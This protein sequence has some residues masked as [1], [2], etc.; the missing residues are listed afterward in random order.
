MSELV[1]LLIARSMLNALNKRPV[2]SNPPPIEQRA[3]QS[4]A[5]AERLRQLAE[6]LTSVIAQKTA[7]LAQ[8]WTPK[9]GREHASRSHDGR[10]LMRC[11]IAMLKLADGIENDSLPATLR[12][13]KWTKKKILGMVST[14]CDTSAGY[15]DYRELFDE[16][17]DNSKRAVSLRLYAGVARAVEQT[18]D[19][20]ALNEIRRNPP[21][22]FFPTPLAVVELMLEKISDWLWDLKESGH[23]AWM[24]E[25]SAGIG[26]LIDAFNE[27]CNE[28]GIPRRFDYCETNIKL[29]DY[30]RDNCDV[31]DNLGFDFMCTNVARNVYNVILMNPP[32]EK[33]QDIDHVRKAYDVLERGGILVAI[34]GEGAF[35]RMDQKARDFRMWLSGLNA[36]VEKLPENSFNTKDAFRR[37]GVQTRI[38]TIKKG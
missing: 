28:L 20:S 1:K 18:E 23:T 31:N 11:Q 33:L 14:K 4:N 8:N 10:N 25:P 22:G 24:L 21:E 29:R 37:T 36:D 27:R 34:M 16:Y 15:Y 32:F 2:K 35:F 6:N 13:V 3:S 26:T 19:L 5:D 38:V 30:V 9:R 17:H 7:P 12:G